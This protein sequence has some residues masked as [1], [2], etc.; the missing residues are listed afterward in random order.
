[1]RRYSLLFIGILTLALFLNCNPTSSNNNSN[2]NGITVTDV[3][4][5][6]YHTV[7][8]GTQTWTVENLRT[9]K[10]NDGTAIPLVTDGT[11]WSNPTTGAYCWYNNDATTNKATYGALYNWYAMH[12]GKLA[13]TGW[14]V[15]AD[16][17]WATLTAFLGGEDSAGGKLKDTTHWSLPNMAATNETGFSALPGGRRNNNG[18]FDGVGDAGFWWSSTAYGATISWASD[19]YNSIANAYRDYASDNYGF[20]VRCV[21]D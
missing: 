17:E 8:I 19:M 1:M 18:S 5:N 2:N 16:S 21:R 20:S 7:K 14:H 12:T 9:T 3:D 6:V 13:P 11:A 4:G 10:Y 15:P